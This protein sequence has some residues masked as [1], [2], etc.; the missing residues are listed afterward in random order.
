MQA[1][2]IA[3]VFDS[4]TLSKANCWISWHWGIF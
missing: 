3:K 2:N 4:C 1:E